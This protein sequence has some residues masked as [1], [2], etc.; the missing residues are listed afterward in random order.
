MSNFNVDIIN[1]IAKINNISFSINVDNT[2]TLR[3]YKKL[4][5]KSTHLIEKNFKIFYLTYEC[6]SKYDNYSINELFP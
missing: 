6:S 4:L 3:K 5:G 1:I 2:T